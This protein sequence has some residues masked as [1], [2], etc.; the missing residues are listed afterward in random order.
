MKRETSHAATAATASSLLSFKLH[1][2]L[3]SMR[4]VWAAIIK[5][6]GV[7]AESRSVEED[8]MLRPLLL[9]S[10]QRVASEG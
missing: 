8:E 4:Q 5:G 10:G 1:L 2:R 3:Y 9:L 6:P 7:E